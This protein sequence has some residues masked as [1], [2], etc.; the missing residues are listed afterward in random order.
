MKWRFLNCLEQINLYRDEDTGKHSLRVGKIAFT[1]ATKLGI[2]DSVCQ[3]IRTF[4]SLHDIG[5]VGIPDKILLKEGK[6]TTEEFNSIKKHPE[7]G[8]NLMRKAKF[9]VIAENITKYHHEKWDGTGYPTGLKGEDIPLE[10]RITII[11]DVYDA[12]RQKRCYKERFTHEIAL[13]ILKKGEHIYFDPYLLKKFMEYEKEFN[14][15]STEECN[16]G[17]EVND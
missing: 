13:E 10:A 11:A 8:F 14:E 7:I 16:G 9:G 1:L 12:L 3:E 15:I 5:K 6:L 2:K 4:A 17:N